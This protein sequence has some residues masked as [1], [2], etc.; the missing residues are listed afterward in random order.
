MTTARAIAD[1]GMNVEFRAR[2]KGNGVKT[3]DFLAGGVCF[4]Y[5]KSEHIAE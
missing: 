3:P 4:R 2:I 1:Y 5:A